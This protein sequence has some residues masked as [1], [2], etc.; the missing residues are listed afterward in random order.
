MSNRVREIAMN[1]RVINPKSQKKK[2]LRKAISAALC[3]ILLLQAVPAE[4]LVAPGENAP[5]TGSQ[6]DGPLRALEPTI[7][8]LVEPEAERGHEAPYI[9]EECVGLREQASKT[10]RK[11]DGTSVA[12]A[13]PT[14]VHFKPPGG[15]EWVDLDLTLR[16]TDRG[17]E[18]RPRRSAW[19]YR[20]T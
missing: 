14:P 2:T 9:V 17:Y 8:E 20:R 1:N 19:C 18:T 5:E 3:V 6:V 13:Y 10:F 7:A 16:Q 12:L 4:A 15:E 11:S